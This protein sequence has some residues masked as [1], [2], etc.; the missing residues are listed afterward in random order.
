[1]VFLSRSILLF[2][3]LLGWSD[4]GDVFVTTDVVVSLWGWFPKP[5]LDVLF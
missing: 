2:C 1:M 3:E 5:P 4:F